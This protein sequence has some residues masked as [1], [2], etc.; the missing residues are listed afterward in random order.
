[1]VARQKNSGDR[2]EFHFLAKVIDIRQ[3]VAFGKNF[4]KSLVFPTRPAEYKK[5]GQNYGPGYDGKY[6]E[7]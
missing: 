1:M 2:T 3:A 7:Q 5:L 6:Q 4:Q